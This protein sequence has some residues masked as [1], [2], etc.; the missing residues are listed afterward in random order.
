MPKRQIG[1]IVPENEGNLPFKLGTAFIITARPAF[2]GS[3]LDYEFGVRLRF[4]NEE[5]PIFNFE[6]GR[7]RASEICENLGGCHRK[8]ALCK[9]C[10]N[11]GVD[12]GLPPVLIDEEP[13]LPPAQLR[14]TVN[15]FE[16]LDK[17]NPESDFALLVGELAVRHLSRRGMMEIVPFGD[18]EIQFT[19]E[20]GKHSMWVR[21]DESD[22]FMFMTRSLVVHP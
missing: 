18:S 12:L 1:R 4:E 21:V 16:T 9:G 6:R 17:D 15:I 3:A 7:V 5:S 8:M 2:R 13:D 20:Y 19:L 10:L 22:L 14:P 11:E